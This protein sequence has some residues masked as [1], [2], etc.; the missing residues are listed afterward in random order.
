MAALVPEPPTHA[1]NVPLLRRVHPHVPRAR[2]R[3]ASPVAPLCYIEHIPPDHTLHHGG[4]RGD[5][6][7]DHEARR[8]AVR[9]WEVKVWLL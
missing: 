4:V 1:L 2:A 3:R 7:E 9:V 8:V 5:S 6:G